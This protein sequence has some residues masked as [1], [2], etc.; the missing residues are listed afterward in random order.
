M[1]GVGD[2]DH[3][4][5]GPGTIEATGRRRLHRVHPTHAEADDADG[6]DAEEI[7][8]REDVRQLTIVLEGRHG[9]HAFLERHPF[10]TRKRFDGGDRPTVLGSELRDEVVEERTKPADVGDHDETATRS[11]A[12]GTGNF[13]RG[14]VGESCAHRNVLTVETRRGHQLRHVGV[15]DHPARVV[16]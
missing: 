16:E 7:G 2:T 4:V 1:P 8:C 12:L 11:V 5:E 3:A 14:A 13:D 10:P 15:L 9:A 6:L